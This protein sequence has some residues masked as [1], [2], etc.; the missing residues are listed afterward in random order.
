VQPIDIKPGHVDIRPT[1]DDPVGQHPPEP[2]AR[3]DPDRV[4]P[5]RHE[6]ILQLGRLAD[7]RQ[8]VRREALGP[9]EELLHPRI[10]QHRHPAH[11]LLD[12]RPHAVPVGRQVA[13]R[14][15]LGHPVTFHGAQ[16]GSNS[17]TIIPPTSSRK[18]PYDPG[19]SSTGHV[20]DSPGIF[21]VIK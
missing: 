4:E 15:V 12:V 18:Y 6:I 8:Q 7:D 16:I 13:E 11:R 10:E 2:A 14:E 9:A 17:P 20:G 3:Q 5:R 19:S 21:S 1:M